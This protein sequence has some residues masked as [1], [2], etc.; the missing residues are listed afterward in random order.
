MESKEAESKD[1]Q[2]D[3]KNTDGG[4]EKGGA[5]DG[6]KPGFINVKVQNSDKIVLFEG[7]VAVG[8][9]LEKIATAYLPEAPEG[10]QYSLF[11]GSVKCPQTMILS[12]L[13]DEPFILLNASYKAVAQRK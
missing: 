8:V 9:S 5:G 3:A 11:E 1:Q 6:P 4:E 10:Q 12:D 13:T 7:E 2:F